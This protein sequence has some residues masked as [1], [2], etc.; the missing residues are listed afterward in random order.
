MTR[1][2][3]RVARFATPLGPMTAVADGQAVLALR[4]GAPRGEGSPD[5]LLRRFEQELFAYFAGELRDFQ[6]P[7]APAGTPFQRRVWDALRQVPFGET[8]SYAAIAGAIG[9]PTATRAVGAANGANPIA[10][11]IPCHRVVRTGGALGGYTGGI[12]FKRRLLEHEAQAAGA[13]L[14]K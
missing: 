8:R 3:P 14:F 10:I 11:A 13:V 12:D 6:T 4:F 9:A 7:F 2:A 1:P 5:A